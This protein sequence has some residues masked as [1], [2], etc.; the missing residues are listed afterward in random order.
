MSRAVCCN[1][2]SVEPCDARPGHS[3]V[4]TKSQSMWWN[5]PD[6]RM[7][8][9]HNWSLPHITRMGDWYHAI[10]VTVRSWSL[11]MRPS[12]HISLVTRTPVQTSEKAQLSNE[13][14]TFLALCLVFPHETFSQISVSQFYQSPICIPEPLIVSIKSTLHQ[15][16]SQRCDGM[17]EILVSAVCTR[18]QTTINRPLKCAIKIIRIDQDDDEL[19]SLWALVML[20][21]PSPTFLQLWVTLCHWPLCQAP[22]RVLAYL[23]SLHSTDRK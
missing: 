5:T 15:Q 17:A 21:W 9:P 20:L 8:D 3:P 10:M 1:S 6:S 16:C 11:V 14:A 12:A 22:G 2:F 4:S 18:H 23:H 19:C 7:R 13:Q